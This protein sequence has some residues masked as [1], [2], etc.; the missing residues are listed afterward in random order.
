MYRNHRARQRIVSIRTIKF[1]TRLNLKA[2]M[3]ISNMHEK[4]DT[5]YS[6]VQKRLDRIEKKQ[7]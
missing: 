5:M 1:G 2:E 7:H 6:E 3:Q 4:F